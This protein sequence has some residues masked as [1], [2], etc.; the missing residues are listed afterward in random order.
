[1]T[2]AFCVTDKKAEPLAYFDNGTVAIAKAD[3]CVYLSMNYIPNALAKKI[4]EDSGVH[5][6]C[7]SGD[8]VIASSGCVLIKCLGSGE[9]KLRL[10]HGGEIQFTSK[11]YE[12]RVYDVETR[13][14]LL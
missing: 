10:P 2:P 14:R 6:W 11:G 12:T 3:N 8:P 5:I 1:M 13:E 7:D 9:R 4:F